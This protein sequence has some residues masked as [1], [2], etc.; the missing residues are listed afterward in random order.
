MLRV[1]SYNFTVFLNKICKCDLQKYQP[2]H[3]YNQFRFCYIMAILA[4]STLAVC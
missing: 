4:N 1:Y 2:N 3:L